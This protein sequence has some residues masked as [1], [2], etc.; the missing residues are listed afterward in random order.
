MNTTLLPSA[1]STPVCQ[2]SSR[3]HLPGTFWL[4]QLFRQRTGFFVPLFWLRAE[5][6]RVSAGAWQNLAHAPDRRNFLH[7]ALKGKWSC[8]TEREPCRFKCAKVEIQ[9]LI[10]PLMFVPVPNTLCQ[11]LATSFLLFSRWTIPHF[12]LYLVIIL[13][14]SGQK[15]A[16]WFVPACMTMELFSY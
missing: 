4:S 2:T 1:S 11:N 13:V 10:L 7:V 8:M 6:G 15:R 14:S 3:D 16:F 9:H 5:R 12:L